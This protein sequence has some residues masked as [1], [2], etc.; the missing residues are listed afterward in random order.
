MERLLSVFVGQTLGGLTAK[1]NQEDLQAV[2]DL[3]EK[4]ELTPVVDRT[5]DL[6]EAADALRYLEQGHPRGKVVVTV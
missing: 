5:F 4:G 6:V 2:A 1:E 3:V